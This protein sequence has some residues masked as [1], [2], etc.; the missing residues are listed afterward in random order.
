MVSVGKLLTLSGCNG[1]APFGVTCIVGSMPYPDTPGVCIRYRSNACKAEWIFGFD[2]VT[3]RY[4]VTP[5]M[6]WFPRLVTQMGSRFGA[7]SS[8]DL[9]QS[10][11]VI[12]R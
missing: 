4:L 8:E 9:E 3:A 7:H 10:P 2:R 6:P 5:S 1:A 11:L 12:L